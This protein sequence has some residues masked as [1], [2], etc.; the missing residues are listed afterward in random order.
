MSETGIRVDMQWTS[1]CQ[2][3]E[4]KKKKKKSGLV[5]VLVM[6][7][8]F[9][10]SHPVPFARSGSRTLSTSPSTSPRREKGAAADWLV[11]IP[12]VHAP[13]YLSM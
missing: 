11:P 4:K 7:P 9:P 12:N 10:T 5:T 13:P 3:K 8:K 1:F 6:Q 2:G